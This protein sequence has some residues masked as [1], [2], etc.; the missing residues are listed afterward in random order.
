M[1]TTDITVRDGQATEP[2]RERRR[3][4]PRRT[5]ILIGALVVVLTA[6]TVTTLAL[7]AA[8]TGDR[9]AAP[10]SR[11]IMDPPAAYQPGGSVYEEQVP[12]Y[13]DWSIGYGPGSYLYNAQVPQ[14]RPNVRIR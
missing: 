12:D 10:P 8:G 9:P 3:R 14:P 11:V 4:R 1:T 6:V 2:T 7:W 5:G 13:Q